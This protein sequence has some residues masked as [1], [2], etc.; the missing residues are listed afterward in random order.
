[1]FT[2]T[3]IIQLGMTT[4]SRSMS[5]AFNQEFK[6]T[7][8]FYF[9]NKIMPPIRPWRLDA[10]CG[11]GKTFL[12]SLIL[13]MIRSQNGIT[14]ALVSSGIATTLLEGGQR[15]HLAHTLLFNM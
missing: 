2:N 8:P 9:S 12:I 10:P 1:M 7:F 3:G 4:P 15:V 6:E 14:L 13:A 11:T 5:D